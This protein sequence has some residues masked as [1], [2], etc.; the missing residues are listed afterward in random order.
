VPDLIKNIGNWDVE[1][2]EKFY[3]AKLG[4]KGS[5]VCAG[6]SS[7]R[8]LHFNQRTVFRPSNDLRMAVNGFEFV[9]SSLERLQEANAQDEKKDRQHINF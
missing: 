6:H 7:K 3:S 9:E 8:G 2:L 1:V 5:Q 4:L